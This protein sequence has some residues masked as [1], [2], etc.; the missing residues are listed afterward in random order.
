MLWSADEVEDEMNT[1][2]AGTVARWYYVTRQD[3]PTG[4]W[5][6]IHQGKRLTVGVVRAA[7]ASSKAGKRPT[8]SR[9]GGSMNKGDIVVGGKN[10]GNIVVGWCWNAWSAGDPNNHPRNGLGC[11]TKFWRSCWASDLF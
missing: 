5:S 8:E 1:D 11:R 9:G 3:V 7:F 10:R 4:V 6:P 2:P